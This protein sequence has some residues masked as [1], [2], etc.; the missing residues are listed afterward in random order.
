MPQGP[1]R[2]DVPVVSHAFW[3]FSKHEQAYAIPAP[4]LLTVISRPAIIKNLFMTIS[5]L[6]ECELRW[7]F[8]SVFAQANRE[9][10]DFPLRDGRATRPFTH[11]Q[12]NLF[13]GLYHDLI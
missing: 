10:A 12:K 1:P 11:V 5:S 3:P 13:Q 4:I 9:N 7:W 8:V 6:G 2:A